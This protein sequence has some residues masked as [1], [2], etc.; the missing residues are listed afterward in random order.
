[1]LHLILINNNDKVIFRFWQQK[2]Q[3]IWFKWFP[4]LS[5]IL[6]DVTMR[7]IFRNVIISGTVALKCDRFYLKQFLRCNILLLNSFFFDYD[8]FYLG[9][10][11]FKFEK[12]NFCWKNISFKFRLALLIFSFLVCSNSLEAVSEYLFVIV[13]LIKKICFHK[14]CRNVLKLLFTLLRKV[15]L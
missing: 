9:R 13:T 2:H 4:F 14:C 10:D 8:T 6:R 5:N 15:Y 7:T 12:I 3:I 11:I 1:M